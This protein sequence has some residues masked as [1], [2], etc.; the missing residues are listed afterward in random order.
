M[1]LHIGWTIL[2]CVLCI[3]IT[4][5]GTIAFLSSSK[6][7]QE[8]IKIHYAKLVLTR[9]ISDLKTLESA[10]SSVSAGNAEQAKNILQS[11]MASDYKVIKGI[12]AGIPENSLKSFLKQESEDADKF[13]KENGGSYNEK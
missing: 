2:V 10:Y 9:Y 1:R 5:A 3:V 12:R 11:K 13:L 6:G 7:V 4:F 8:Y